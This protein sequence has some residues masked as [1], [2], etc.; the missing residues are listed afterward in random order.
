[1]KKGI[2]I[3]LLTA[4]ILLFMTTYG[5]AGNFSEAASSV[6]SMHLAGSLTIDGEPAEAGDEVAVFDNKGNLL[7]SFVVEN[8][9]MYG[10]MSIAG[11][12]PASS[13]DEGAEEGE[14]LFINVYKAS[15]GITYSGGKVKTLSP[16][17]G[18]AIYSPYSK[19]VLK[20]EGGSFVLLDIQAR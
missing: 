10:D 11:N 8:K 19:P 13:E 2:K 4:S 17:E 14:V 9:G 12:Y 7:G 20:F 3:T 5:F 16:T 1:M 18:N 15:T 6:I